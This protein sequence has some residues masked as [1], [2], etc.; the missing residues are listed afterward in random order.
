MASVGAPD[1]GPGSSL[2]PEEAVEKYKYKSF[3]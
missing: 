2:L 3:K 1:S